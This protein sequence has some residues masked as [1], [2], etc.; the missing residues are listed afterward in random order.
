MKERIDHL[1]GLSHLPGE[2]CPICHPEPLESETFKYDDET[3][4]K[5]WTEVSPVVL[6]GDKKCPHGYTKRAACTVCDHEDDLKEKN[7]EIDRLR[8]ALKEAM[9]WNWMQGDI[10]QRVIDQCE[11]ALRR[12]SYEQPD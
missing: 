2:P 5:L 7:A 11:A 10:P 6:R 3:S 4:R 8:K 1:N 12:G 9:E